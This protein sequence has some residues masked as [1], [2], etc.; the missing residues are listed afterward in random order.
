MNSTILAF[1]YGTSKI[2]VAVGQRITGTASP[3]PPITARD[4]VPDWAGIETVL[5]Q[6]PSTECLVGVP[7][8]MDG[9]ES[10]MSARARRFANQLRGRFGLTC[11]EVDERLS[12]REARDAQR[13]RDQRRGRKHDPRGHIDSLAACVILEA[14]LAI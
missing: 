7:F 9:S 5:R 6:W 14:W 2:G 11:H 4:G 13:Q 10:E 3:L 8:N 1:D 12:S